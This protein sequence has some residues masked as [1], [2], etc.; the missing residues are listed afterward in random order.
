MARVSHPTDQFQVMMGPEDGLCFPIIRSPLDIGADPRCAINPR[1]DPAI[2]RRI[3]RVTVVS[4]GYRV[5]RAGSER[6]L[7]GGRRAGLVFSRIARDGEVIQVGQTK[8]LVQCAP[9]G[10]AQRSRGLPG[11]SDAA[12]LAR[13]ALR[14][15]WTGVYRICCSVRASLGRCFWPI[16]AVVVLVTLEY[17]F[18][19]L[20]KAT[21]G[22]LWY[23]L[24][25]LR[26]YL[27]GFAQS[28]SG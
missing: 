23:L 21:V 15:G 24:R 8:L 18:P 9:G 20:L 17:C 25:W 12:W 22:R 16:I 14:K 2:P 6:V 4:E 1:M 5:R 7:V 13:L 11:E 3:A 10:L 27:Q 26:Y 28:L 19:G